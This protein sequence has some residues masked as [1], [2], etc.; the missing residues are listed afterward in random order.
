MNVLIAFSI[1]FVRCVGVAADDS[2]RELVSFDVE[3]HGALITLPLTL[4]N[5]EYE[6][7]L[8]CGATHHVF[9][10]SLRPLLGDPVRTAK[11]KDDSGSAALQL[12]ASPNAFIGPLPLQSSKVIALADLSGIRAASGSNVRGIIGLDFFNDRVVR[13][14]FDNGTVA[15][16][17]RGEVD[18]GSG[19]TLPL[20]L[21][22]KGHVCVDVSIG[23][24][25][26]VSM[27]IDTGSTGS[28]SLPPHAFRYCVQR[29]E[30]EVIG[31]RAVS[32]LIGVN[33]HPFGCLSTFRCGP[34]THSQVLAKELADGT[35]G[36]AY[37]ARYKVTFDVTGGVLHLQPG[38]RFTDRDI[39]DRSG[40]IL[41]EVDDVVVVHDVEAN[42]P[43]TGHR[44]EKG[45]VIL[46][47]NQ[48]PASR[49]SLFAIRRILCGENGD[50]VTLQLR[51]N[52]TDLMF[53][54]YLSPPKCGEVEPDQR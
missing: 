41:L 24:L 1:C 33:R 49:H 53:E 2:Q 22:T 54:L 51:R 45:D 26:E 37:L 3:K 5:N 4:G 6:F 10:S 7:V 17:R 30:L 48:T 47:I 44:I 42:S 27:L 36:L 34:F 11:V 50:K 19:V 40:L 21:D 32:T 43:A 25:N 35:I 28:I 29:N 14:D 13:I 15:V 23:S 31:M 39:A 52:Q 8:D 9:D 20:R 16:F 12:F 18:F 46:A 38:K